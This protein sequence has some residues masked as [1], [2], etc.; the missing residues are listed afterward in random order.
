MNIIGSNLRAAQSYPGNARL[1]CTRIG[2]RDRGS[3]Q[4]MPCPDHR[5]RVS[6]WGFPSLQVTLTTYTFSCDVSAAVWEMDML[7]S[8]VTHS[9]TITQSERILILIN[10]LYCTG[11]LLRYT[12]PTTSLLRVQNEIILYRNTS[13]KLVVLKIFRLGICS[14]LRGNHLN[15]D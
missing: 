4:F 12:V 8:Y 5:S 1:H 7:G 3:R 14:F 6:A 2:T 9:W 13:F 10:F 15:A 11:S